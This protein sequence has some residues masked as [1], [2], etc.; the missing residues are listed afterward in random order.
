MTIRLAL[1]SALGLA[2]AIPAASVAENLRKGEWDYLTTAD[3]EYSCYGRVLSRMGDQV[4]M[5]VLVAN[6]KDEVEKDYVVTYAIECKKMAI[7]Q[8]GGK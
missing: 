8:S 4:V 2:I 6:P 5:K 7:K 3:D 1:L